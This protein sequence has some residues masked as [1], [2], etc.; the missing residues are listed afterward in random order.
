MEQ[1]RATHWATISIRFGSAHITTETSI[2]EDVSARLYADRVL[3]WH[4]GIARLV[5]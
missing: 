2:S 3:A 1:H 4:A 5:V